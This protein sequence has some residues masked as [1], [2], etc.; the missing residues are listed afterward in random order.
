MVAEDVEIVPLGAAEIAQVDQVPH[1]RAEGG[2]FRGL[3]G[4][5]VHVDAAGDDHVGA[6]VRRTGEVP[7]GDAGLG[8][9][10]DG[11][12]LGLAVPV[13]VGGGRLL[14][15][16]AVLHHVEGE[17]VP[18]DLVL[19]GAG[20]EG[21]RHRLG[22]E[23]GGAQVEV[24]RRIRRAGGVHQLRLGR[25]VLAPFQDVRPLGKVDYLPLERGEVA[26][27][28]TAPHLDVELD[29]GVQAAQHQHGPGCG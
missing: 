23:V 3:I 4:D 5:V 21:V 8:A 7:V 10:L 25:T 6:H 9:R 14:G 20:V 27:P 11:V 28:G 17:A 22:L 12:L 18:Q 26:D 24:I 2:A 19:R 13:G 15:R 16:L 1:V 29:L